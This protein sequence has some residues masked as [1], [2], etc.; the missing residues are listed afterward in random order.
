MWKNPLN[1]WVKKMGSE[2]RQESIRDSFL[3]VAGREW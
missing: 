2:K 1:S 3:G